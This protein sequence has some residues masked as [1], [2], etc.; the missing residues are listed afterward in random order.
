MG[1]REGAAR[2]FVMGTD[3]KKAASGGKWGVYWFAFERQNGNS[4]FNVQSHFGTGNW[5]AAILSGGIQRRIVSEEKPDVARRRVPFQSE[6]HT[7]AAA[8]KLT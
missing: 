6:I 8:Q 3:A 1:C 5:R 2:G 7:S 4:Q